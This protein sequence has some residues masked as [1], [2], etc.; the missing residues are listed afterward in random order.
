MVTQTIGSYVQDTAANI[1]VGNYPLSSCAA[2]TLLYATDT[3]IFYVQGAAGPTPLLSATTKKYSTAVATS[4]AAV[5]S[6]T[7]VAVGLANGPGSTTLNGGTAA[8]ATSAVFTVN[9]NF[10][11]GENVLIDGASSVAEIA[12]I[13]TINGTTITFTSALLNAHTTAH[14]VVGMYAGIQPSSTGRLKITMS[15][16]ILAGSTASTCTIQPYIGS[17]ITVAAPANGAAFDA[18]AVA[19]GQTETWISLTGALEDTFYV[20]CLLGA[21][22]YA[23]DTAPSGG[24]KRTVGT[25]YYI[26]LGVTSSTGT[27]QVIKPVIVIEEV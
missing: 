21:N 12:T 27:F 3:G 11:V 14:T 5:T 22:D 17:A 6:A 16:S 10:F 2:G 20:T 7:V 25:P 4:P 18:S 1:T 24:A 19:V 26:D 13:K 15:G 9:T 23:T 8:G